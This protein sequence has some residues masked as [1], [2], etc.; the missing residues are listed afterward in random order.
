MTAFWLWLWTALLVLQDGPISVERLIE[1]L[2]AEASSEQQQVMERFAR[3]E[4]A[5]ASIPALLKLLR[6]EAPKMDNNVCLAIQHI[7]VEHPEA[8]CPLDPLLET[9]DRRQWRSQQKGAQALYYALKEPAMKGRAEELC[10]HLIP[11]LISQRPRVYG[12]ALDCLKKIT[13]H[14]AGPDPEA[15]KKHYEEKFPGRTLDLTGA[16]YEL[17]VRAPYRPPE[18]VKE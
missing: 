12:A 13:G 7:L 6:D 16:M 11:L 5:P 17:L 10:R 14:D 9:I 3:Q 8:E 2:R 1:Q 18:A 15:W 4:D